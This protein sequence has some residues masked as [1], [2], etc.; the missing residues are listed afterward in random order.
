MSPRPLCASAMDVLGLLWRV[1]HALG[2][3]SRLMLDQ[4][5][6]TSPQRVALRA[7]LQEPDT[8][9]AGVAELLRV[10]RSSVSGMLQRLEDAGFITRSQADDDGRKRRVTVTDAGRQVDGL[11]H[12]T[13]EAA[14]ERTLAAMEPAEIEIATRFLRTFAVQ[15][16]RERDV[17]TMQP[18]ED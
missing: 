15:L 4:L 17:L 5:G 11:R 8:T 6:V 2:K 3:L 14:M 7:F 16:D 1:D 13:V 9:A 12:G 10:D 18:G